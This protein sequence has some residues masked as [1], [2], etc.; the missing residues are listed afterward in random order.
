M[1]KQLRDKTYWTSSVKTSV[2]GGLATI[3]KNNTSN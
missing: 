1:A 3:Q 2:E